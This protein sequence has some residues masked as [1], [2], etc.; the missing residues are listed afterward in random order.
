MTKIL[1]KYYFIYNINFLKM[2]NSGFIF[3]MCFQVIWIYLIN[4]SSLR[5]FS[6][7]NFTKIRSNFINFIIL[8][9]YIFIQI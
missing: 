1:F 3:S 8:N 5:S 9:N 2:F 7:N 4:V 6:K